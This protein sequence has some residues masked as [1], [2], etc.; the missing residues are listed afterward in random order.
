MSRVLEI[1]KAIESLSAEEMRQLFAW[2]EEKQAM[3][4]ATAGM[5]SLYDEEEGEGDQ[6]HE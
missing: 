4:A 3:T 2:M 1:E 6:W 5:F